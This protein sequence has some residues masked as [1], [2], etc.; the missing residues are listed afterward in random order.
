MVDGF[1]SL[2]F[3]DDEMDSIFRILAAI[4]NLGDVK[5]YQ[6]IDKDNMEQATIK[7]VDQIRLGAFKSLYN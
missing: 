5:F 1:K 2:G 6:T 4:I 3:H 7:N